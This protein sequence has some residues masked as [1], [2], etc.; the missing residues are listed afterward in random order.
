MICQ[1]CAK[2]GDLNKEGQFDQAITAHKD[3]QSPAT[4]PCLHR[5]GD[6][7]LLYHSL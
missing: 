1:P 6:S 4:C 5:T 2:A 7:S 3:C